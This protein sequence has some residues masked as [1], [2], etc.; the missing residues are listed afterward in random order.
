MDDATPQTKPGPANPA[1]KGAEAPTPPEGP[2]RQ[3]AAEGSLPPSHDD[4][5]SAGPAANR[6]AEEAGGH[7]IAL[8]DEQP[9]A[10]PASQESDIARE[11]A[12]TSLDQ[13]SEGSA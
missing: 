2:L 7:T 8:E 1:A 13:P 11:N 12:E 5:A 6:S 9:D 3:D 10:R 4:D